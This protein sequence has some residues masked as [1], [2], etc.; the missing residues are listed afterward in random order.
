MYN[1]KHICK[2]KSDDLFLNMKEDNHDYDY[3]HEYEDEY[4]YDYARNIFYKADLLS[5]FCMEKFDE[6]MINENM[7]NLYEKIKEVSE[8]KDCMI[9]LS[10]KYFSTDNVLGLMLLYSYDYLYLT[11]V[12]VSDYLEKG[13]IDKENLCKLKSILI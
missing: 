4:D 11:H 13:I 3:H 8:L 5:I 1:T 7:N 10:N 2:Y 9:Q 12:C 6:N